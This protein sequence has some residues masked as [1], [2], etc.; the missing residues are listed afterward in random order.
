MR[1][2]IHAILTLV[3]LGVPATASTLAIESFEIFGGNGCNAIPE[4]N[5]GFSFVADTDLTVTALGAYDSAS[6]PISGAGSTVTLYDFDTQE[7]LG[8]TTVTASSRLAGATITGGGLAGDYRMVDLVTP[9]SLL[10]GER[11]MLAA[12]GTL[13][14]LPDPGSPTIFNGISDVLGYFVSGTGFPTGGGTSTSF[15]APNLEYQTAVIPLPA[16][17]PLLAS[18]LLGL[19][20]LVRLRRRPAGA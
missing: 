13:A 4:F 10:A 19:F 14:P 17:L 11:Y 5:C 20:G 2:L 9:I 6:S 7:V 3:T 15:L 12:L 18:V 8:T 1:R 16:S